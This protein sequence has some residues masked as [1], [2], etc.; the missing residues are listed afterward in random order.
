MEQNDISL[1]TYMRTYFKFVVP[2]CALIAL[3]EELLNESSFLNR[4]VKDTV[5]E[6]GESAE[7]FLTAAASVTP[8]GERPG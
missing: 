1:M 5:L 6:A 2:L 8:R 7:I 4:Q 3:S